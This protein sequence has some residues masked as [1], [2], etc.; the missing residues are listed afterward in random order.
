MIEDCLLDLSPHMQ[1]DPQ[2]YV[3][4]GRAG[5]EQKRD[6]TWAFTGVQDQLAIDLY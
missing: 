3:G 6:G 1:M 4:L 5:P 2:W